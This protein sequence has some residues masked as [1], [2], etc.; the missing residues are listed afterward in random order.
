MPESSDTTA[1]HLQDVVQ[2]TAYQTVADLP[3]LL[4]MILLNL[5]LPDLL[6]AQIVD[7]TW[8]AVIRDS[9]TLQQALFFQPVP[10]KMCVPGDE[11]QRVHACA[12]RLV[13]EPAAEPSDGPSKNYCSPAQDTATLTGMRRT[14]WSSIHSCRGDFR[15]CSQKPATRR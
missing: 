14:P 1:D 2:R 5:P 15:G 13:C 8:H 12:D 7:R 3:E 9:P 11:P 10:G 6:I 4:E